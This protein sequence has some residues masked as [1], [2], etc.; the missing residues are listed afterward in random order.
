VGKNKRIEHIKKILEDR[1]LEPIATIRN[2][3]IVQTEGLRRVNRENK[4]YNP[5]IIIAGKF[6]VNSEQ[7][8]L[9]QKRANMIDK[10]YTIQDWVIGKK[11]F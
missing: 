8:V 1:K 9:F 7:T 4:H 11:Q 6:K 5:Q 2:F 10:D 3:R